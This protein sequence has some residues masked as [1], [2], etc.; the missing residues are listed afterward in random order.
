M[1]NLGGWLGRLVMRWLL[2][3]IGIIVVLGVIGAGAFVFARPQIDKVV[4][5]YS[6]KYNIQFESWDVSVAG[7]VNVNNVRM[8]LSDGTI[9]KIGHVSGRPPVLGLSGTAD[10]Y[11]VMIERDG[12][13]IKVPEL[14]VSGVSQEK[15]DAGEPS[16]TLRMLK[17]FNVSSISAPRVQLVATHDNEKREVVVKGFSL[18]SL[19]AGKIGRIGFSTLETD[20]GQIT[21]GHIGG[22]QLHSGA[23]SI[24]DVDAAE[25]YAFITGRFDAGETGKGIVGPVNLDDIKIDIR[26]AKGDE[27]HF[28]LGTLKSA[29]LVLRAPKTSPLETIKAFRLAYQSDGSEEEK[30][31]ATRDLLGLTQSIASVDAEV[32]DVQFDVPQVKARLD[33]FELKP[34]NWNSVVPEGLRINL[35][36]LAIDTTHLEGEKAE[37][38][39]S[40]G[41][42]KLE[43]SFVFDADWQPDSH[44][45][46]LKEFSFVGKN[47]GQASF[48]GTFIN[49]QPGLFSGDKT[50]TLAAVSGL[51]LS[52]MNMSFTDFGAIDH[53]INWEVEQLSP[54]DDKLRRELKDD[55]YEMATKSPP[56][57]FNNHPDTQQMS[58]ALGAFVRDSGT[59]N[60]KIVAKKKRGIN[61]FDIAATQDLKQF[62]D[63]VDL[64]FINV[65]TGKSAASAQ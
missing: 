57:M 16:K 49:A 56:L 48:M 26:S 8:P 29:G 22:A 1:S 65:A 9:V 15:D 38:L 59:L 20:I 24:R 7:K 53:V 50:S 3:G 55:L 34:R 19:K 41:Y 36:G 51:A 54:G 4:S 14:Y 64:T 52:E 12:I 5:T 13:S 58:E 17:Q 39:R 45:I 43:F 10:L 60:V 11:D 40:L 28:S 6:Q 18:S 25:A 31:K 32:R 44:T 63:M 23:F 42:N 61:M 47:I 46:A 27:V 37:M 30:K 62:L 33:L 35:G 21:Q 2:Y